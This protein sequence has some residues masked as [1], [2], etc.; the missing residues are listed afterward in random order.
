MKDKN[1]AVR[2]LFV[3]VLGEPYVTMVE[4]DSI[5][6]VLGCDM[7]TYTYDESFGGREVCWHYIDDGGKL[8]GS[9]GLGGIR[10]NRAVYGA[11]GAPVDLVDIVCGDFLIGATTDAK[12][13]DL[14][15]EAILYY[16]ERYHDTMSGLEALSRIRVKTYLGGLPVDYGADS[17]RYSL[18]GRNLM[19]EYMDKYKGTGY[20]SSYGNALERWLDYWQDSPQSTVDLHKLC[21]DDK[22]LSKLSDTLVSVW[23]PVKMALQLS[24][25]S[26][27]FGE[28]YLPNKTAEVLD[29]VKS[30]LKEYLPREENSSLYHLAELAELDYN[31]WVLPRA[32]MQRR[33]DFRYAIYD[34][35]A[36]SIAALFPGGAFSNL[37]NAEDSV[38]RFI[39]G[40]GLGFLFS[41]DYAASNLRPVI[42][43]AEPG[44]AV[45][46]SNENELNELLEG[47]IELIEQRAQVFK[48]AELLDECRQ[49]VTSGQLPLP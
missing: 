17:L 34:Q 10:P 26:P 20:F 46:A 24:E 43:T 4:P 14:P 21:F 9:I 48:F 33:G 40:E 39:E 42:S 29:Q 16:K 2:M 12:S 18:S 3:P 35:V 11:G 49:R 25:H 6:D 28:R 32:E 41:G 38:C 31:V 19:R 5:C 23:C 8:A 7:F 44:R 22:G 15:Q 13:V 37:L 1:K 45:W 27:W 30:N 36:P 47:M